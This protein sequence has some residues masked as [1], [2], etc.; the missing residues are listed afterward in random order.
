MPILKNPKREKFTQQWASGATKADAYRA[1]YPASK[2]WKPE[3][4]HKRASELSKTGEVL[5]RF[6]ELKS[7]AAKRAEIKIADVIGELG[8]LGF[9]NMSNYVR[10]DAE[11]QPEIC[12]EELTVD[13]WAA[14]SEITTERMEL[15]SGDDKIPVVKTK[16]K[17]SDKRQAL[18]DIGKHLGAFKDDGKNTEIHIH[19]DRHDERA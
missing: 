11:G 3:T 1:A 5:G 8:K 2:N 19:L 12:L 18:V 10:L 6:E 7:N 17:V 14:V 4:V 9:S 13:E 15:G 16:I